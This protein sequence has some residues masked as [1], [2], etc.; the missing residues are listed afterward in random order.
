MTPASEH[1]G[2]KLY[3]R[4]LASHLRS[5]GKNTI[6]VSLRV[7]ASDGHATII[8]ATSLWFLEVRGRKIVFHSR[9]TKDTTKTDILVYYLSQSVK[10]NTDVALNVG[11]VSV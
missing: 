3:F 1:I 4:L 8:K 6:L 2:I 9:D 11:R 5:G 7:L 10:N